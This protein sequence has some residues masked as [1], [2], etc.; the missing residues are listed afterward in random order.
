M[1]ITQQE[2]NLYRNE[3]NAQAD[4]AARYVKKAMDAYFDLYPNW[5]TASAR[6]ITIEMMKTALP[7]FI[8][9]AATLSADFFD[10]IAESLGVKAESKLYDTMDYS[11]IDDKVRY[12]AKF[13]NNGDI[14]AF[15]ENVTDVTGYFVKR[16]AF[17]NMYKNC[18]GNKMF[19]ARVPTGL[20]TCAFCFMLASRGFVYE[21]ENSAEI[22]RR[23]GDKYHTNCDC[24][25]VPGAKGK[26]GD[27][28]V[29]I[30]GYNPKA[31]Y[32]S[33]CKCADAVG[34]DHGD[35]VDKWTDEERNAVMKEVET[36]DW[37]WLYTGELPEITYSNAELKRYKEEKYPHEIETAKKLREYGIKCDFVRDD[38]PEVVKGKKTGNTI[39]YADFG[40]GYELKR[41]KEA[42]S[43]NTIN[44]YLKNTSKKK[45][46]K[47]V[48]FD[49]MGNE[50]MS[51]AQLIEWVNQSKTFSRGRVYIIDHDGEYRFIR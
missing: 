34:V 16:S 45:N 6:S 51:D 13:L 37:H 25:I 18:I 47:Y 20:E 30:D 44:G 5:D 9:S 15:K 3:V 1:R 27:P 42:S 31:M 2:L 49:N 46:A 38:I 11:V 10:E 21:S 26:D 22:A 7:N 19:Y 50:S 4:M 32:E 24:I 48:V 36:R 17:E 14:D 29:V 8:D 23:T 43:Y 12:F 40:S 41:T 28:R 35:G 39:S 33:W